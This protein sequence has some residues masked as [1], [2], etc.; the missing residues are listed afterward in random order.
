MFCLGKTH[1]ALCLLLVY[2]MFP[3]GPVFFPGAAHKLPLEA[4]D[5]QLAV[6]PLAALSLSEAVSSISYIHEA[7]VLS[8]V[9]AKKNTLLK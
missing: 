1:I 7:L 2:H 3:Q 8:P 4:C 6:C 5:V 9:F